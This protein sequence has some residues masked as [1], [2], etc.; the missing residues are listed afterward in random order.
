MITELDIRNIYNALEKASRI[1]QQYPELESIWN[2]IE[3]VIA[4]LDCE[5]ETAE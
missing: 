4:N 3:D 1:A 5:L 2:Q